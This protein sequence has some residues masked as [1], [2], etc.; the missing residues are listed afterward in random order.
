MG[1]K[2]NILPLTV[3]VRDDYTPTARG[4]SVDGVLKFLY[5]K[6]HINNV[7]LVPKKFDSW[8]G[9]CHFRSIFGSFPVKFPPK[10]YCTKRFL[11]EFQRKVSRAIF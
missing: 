11:A 10:F 8:S 6:S 9:K 4:G 3:T 5:V 7:F 2:L 1:S